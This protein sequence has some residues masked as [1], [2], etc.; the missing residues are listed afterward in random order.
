M[1]E[2]YKASTLG[3]RRPIEERTASPRR[4]KNAN[5]VITAW[6]RRIA[7]W[8]FRR[9]LTDFSATSPTSRIW[10]SRVSHQKQGIGKELMRRSKAVRKQ[11][12]F[13]SPHPPAEKYYPCCRF[14]TRAECLAAK[15]GGVYSLISS[16]L[17]N[18]GAVSVPPAVEPGVSARRNNAAH[19]YYAGK[20][21]RKFRAARCRLPRQS[22]RP[23]ATLIRMDKFVRLCQTVSVGQGIQGARIGARQRA[24][25]PRQCLLPELN[26]HT[27]FTPNEAHKI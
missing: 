10:P 4:A 5:L 27:L 9:S 20:F 26:F 12:C 23:A 14:Q 18:V 17:Q 1:V 25:D 22:G 13:S 24:S 19:F 11:P 2:L 6:G 8:H 16:A 7:R 15:A 3:E 21:A